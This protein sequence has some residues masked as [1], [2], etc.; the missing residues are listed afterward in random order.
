M[1]ISNRFLQCFLQCNLLRLL[2][3]ARFVALLVVVAITGCVNASVQ[4]IR[5][6][7]RKSTRLNSSHG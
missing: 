1:N 7:D 3:R 5:Q 4:E 6:G 2:R